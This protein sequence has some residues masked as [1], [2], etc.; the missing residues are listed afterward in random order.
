MR[1]VELSRVKGRTAAAAPHHHDAP[2]TI[3]VSISN[4]YTLAALVITN[5]ISFS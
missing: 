2:T 3:D 5:A 1:K 4:H